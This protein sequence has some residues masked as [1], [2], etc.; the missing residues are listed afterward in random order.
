[1]IQPDSEL[2]QIS[3]GS[4]FF[5]YFASIIAIVVVFLAIVSVQKVAE[6]GTAYAI[7]YQLTKQL[8]ARTRDSLSACP[9]V[10]RPR[11]FRVR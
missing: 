4:V 6:D 10:P 2:R 5:T 3:C 11:S 1:M 7:V 9:S 8:A